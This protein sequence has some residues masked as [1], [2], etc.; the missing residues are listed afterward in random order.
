M[1][2]IDL[3]SF[4]GYCFFMVACLIAGCSTETQAPRNTS[5]L[6]EIRAMQFVPDVIN[7]AEGD[8]ITFRNDDIL[9][10]DVTEDDKAWGSDTLATG[11][12]YSMVVKKSEGFFCTIHP[13]MK[14]QILV[15]Q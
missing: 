6:V 9:V 2:N 15:E 8:T 4:K 12:S 14:G 7:A 5:H 10:H 1:K 11:Q 13:T 3:I